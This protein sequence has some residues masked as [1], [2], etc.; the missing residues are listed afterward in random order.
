MSYIFNSSSSSAI[1]F[2]ILFWKLLMDAIVIFFMWISANY[3]DPTCWYSSVVEHWSYEQSQGSQGSAVRNYFPV[4]VSCLSASFLLFNYLQAT[5]N[6]SGSIKISLLPPGPAGQFEKIVFASA[7]PKKNQKNR[8]HEN[9]RVRLNE[10]SW[11]SREYSIYEC[12][13]QD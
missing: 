10:H 13:L 1:Y 8:I 4:P 6:Q 11:F 12:V 2:S 3:D 9:G 7:A 5:V